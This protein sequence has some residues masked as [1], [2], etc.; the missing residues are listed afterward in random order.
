M[1]APPP[2][3]SK[4]ALAVQ[5][6]VAFAVAL[7]AI[8]VVD[9]FLLGDRLERHHGLIPRVLTGLDGIVAAPL[10]HDDLTHVAANLLPLFVLGGLVL[11][12]GLDRFLVVTGIVALGG[13]LATWLV[14]RSGNHVG[15]SGL[16]FGYLGYLLAAAFFERSFRAIAVAVVVGLVY[17]GL[18]WGILPTNPGVSFE[19][20]LF[21][22]LAGIAA[23]RLTA[24][25]RQPAAV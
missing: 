21:G 23:A 16:V 22:F 4:T 19:G 14:A 3:R 24:P 12:R 10:L 17:G 9:A 13:G 7:V 25:R 6:M 15:A 11:L 8:E 20:H 5:V 2:P 1:T 18:L